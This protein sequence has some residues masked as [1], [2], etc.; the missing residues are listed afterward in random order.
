M[1][2]HYSL[3]CV[4]FLMIRRPPRSTLD[5]SSAASDVYKRQIFFYGLLVFTTKKK[6]KILSKKSQKLA[7]KFRG[8][9]SDS[10]ISMNTVKAEGAERRELSK[11]K[12]PLEDMRKALVKSNIFGNVTSRVSTFLAN[13]FILMSLVFAAILYINGS[14]ELATVLITTSYL[15]LIHISEPTRPY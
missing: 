12:A 5:R 1:I 7:T 10:I 13:L 6:R 2:L 11:L 3:F 8:K 15:S 4:F 9:F 14:I